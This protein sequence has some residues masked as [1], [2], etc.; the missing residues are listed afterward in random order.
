[1]IFA[2]LIFKLLPVTVRESTFPNI[3]KRSYMSFIKLIICFRTYI[4]PRMDLIAT[5]D[6][7]PQ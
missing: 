3:F 5:W 1:M 2:M 7:S 4:W 6:H